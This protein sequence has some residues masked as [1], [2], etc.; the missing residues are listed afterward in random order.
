MSSV[1]YGKQDG[2]IRDA[3]D[4]PGW[5]E[6]RVEPKIQREMD[7]CWTW[8]AGRTKGYAT[9]H[10]PRSC[11]GRGVR[12][13]RVV[14]LRLR[15]EIDDDMVL[16][17]DGPD[18][19]HNKACVNPD[20]LQVVTVRHNNVVT[21]A[22]IAAVNSRKVACPKGHLLEGENLVPAQ[23]ARGERSCLRCN[24]DRANRRDSVLR[25]AAA[26]L[27][28]TL[29][30]YGRHHGQTMRVALGVIRTAAVAA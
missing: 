3:L 25:E 21:G 29:H 20:H 14:W 7:G 13:S 24:H 18:G 17:H 10:L 19:C 6:A 27:G 8:T 16:D 12:G 5:Y 11:G 15:G 22:S 2:M 9:M 1:F 4:V 30:A 23:V 26:I 28:L